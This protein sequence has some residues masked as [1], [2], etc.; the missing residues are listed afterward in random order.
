M[1]PTS[2]QEELKGLHK[3]YEDLKPGARGSKWA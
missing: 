3:L 2:D 1:T